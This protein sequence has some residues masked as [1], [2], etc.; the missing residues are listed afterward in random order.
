MNAHGATLASSMSQ[1]SQSCQGP[2]GIG[3]KVT[4]E[5]LFLESLAQAGLWNSLCIFNWPQTC[6][7]SPASAFQVLGSQA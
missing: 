4:L 1:V 5:F 3:V 2:G 6:G 7:K